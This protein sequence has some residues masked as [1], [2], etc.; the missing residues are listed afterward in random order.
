MCF[1]H[2]QIALQ[3]LLSVSLIKRRKPGLACCINCAGGKGCLAP[4]NRT[5]FH[6]RHHS[7][8]VL[9]LLQ[10]IQFVPTVLEN[11]GVK[12]QQTGIPA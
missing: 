9:G 4:K 3:L 5:D 2:H 7:N 11:R 8:I 1:L 10:S 6:Q 12:Y